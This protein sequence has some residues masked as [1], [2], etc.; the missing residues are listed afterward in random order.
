MAKSGMDAMVGKVRRTGKPAQ[1]RRT[2]HPSKPHNF[3]GRRIGGPACSTRDSRVKRIWTV[4]GVGLE[5]EKKSPGFKRQ[6]RA[7]SQ[8]IKLPN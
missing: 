8:K 4:Q 2:A 5:I 7:A 3:K 1:M 6:R